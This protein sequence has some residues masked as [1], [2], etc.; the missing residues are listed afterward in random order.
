MKQIKRS[1]SI[2]NVEQIFDIIEQG[3]TMPVRC[4]LENGDNVVVKYMKN[5]MGEKILVNEWIG[6]NIADFIGLTVPEYGICDFTLEAIKHTNE[7]EEINELNAGKS[8]YTKDYSKS[9]PIIRGMLN[10]VENRETE[11]IILFDH[12]VNNKDRHDGNLLCNIS[13][14]ARLLVIDNSHI[15]TDEPHHPFIISE[16][17][18]EAY[19]LSNDILL[20]NQSIY[21]S[22]CFEVGYSEDKLM[23]YAT[24]I[25]YSLTNDILEDIRQRIPVEWVNVLGETR[26][27]QLFEVLNKRLSL[28][29]NIAKMIIEERRRL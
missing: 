25:K 8:F 29:E 9:L 23:E 13:K 18:D 15:I 6:T 16:A 11:K 12:L 17:L 19:I 14:G 24:E 1:T 5:P 7:N 10:R 22:L 28:I 26:V 21:D 3:T 4:R 2:I 27:N 20:K